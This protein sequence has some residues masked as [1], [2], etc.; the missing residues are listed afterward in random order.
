MLGLKD[1]NG[2]INISLT[3]AVVTESI[4]KISHC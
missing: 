1:W 4:F 3:L 2:L